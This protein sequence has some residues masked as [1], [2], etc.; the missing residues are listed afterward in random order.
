MSETSA[1]VLLARKTKRLREETG[2]SKLKSKL[3]SGLSPRDLFMYSIVRP[4]KMLTRS[5]ICFLISLYTAITYS[6]LYIMFTTFTSVYETQ[7]H[8]HGGIV[9]LSF[10][11]LGIGSLCG[12]LVFTYWGNKTAAKHITRGDFKP[13][14]RLYIM[15]IGGLFLPLGL[16]WY[17]WAVS[18]THYMVPIVGTGI[19]GFGLLMTCK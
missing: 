18:R 15:C 6:Y 10:L 2:N 5:L 14:H 11:G 17:G 19:M 3:D 9:G 12:Q 13:E 7:Y 4:T 8:W 1:P 16:F